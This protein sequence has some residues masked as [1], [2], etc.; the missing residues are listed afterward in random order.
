MMR[1][2]FRIWLIMNISMAL[3]SEI[4]SDPF[5]TKISNEILRLIESLT[6]FS[7]QQVH[8]SFIIYILSQKRSNGSHLRISTTLYELFN[9]KSKPTNLPISTSIDYPREQNIRVLISLAT[10]TAVF[11]FMPI[12]IYQV[13]HLI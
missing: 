11:L 4:T 10:L 9:K 8:I 6:T 3:V 13:G 2:G 5:K 1:I 12:S 7:H